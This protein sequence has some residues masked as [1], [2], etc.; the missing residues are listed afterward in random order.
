[1]IGNDLLASST[2]SNHVIDIAKIRSKVI[3]DALRI[4]RWKKGLKVN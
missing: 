1:M 3:C 4:V 2:Y